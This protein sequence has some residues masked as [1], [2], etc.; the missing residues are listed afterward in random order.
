MSVLIGEEGL[1]EQLMH[2]SEE[3]RRLAA[4][5]Q[6]YSKQL[7]QLSSRHVLS[8]EEKVQE[9]TLKKKKLFLKDQMYAMLSRYRKEVEARS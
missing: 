2:K 8:E 4:E 9:I 1:R 7:D 5:H 3:F 6:S